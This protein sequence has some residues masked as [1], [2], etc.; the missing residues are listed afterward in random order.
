M[1]NFKPHDLKFV[2]D[3]LFVPKP[4]PVTVIP[5]PSGPLVGLIDWMDSVVPVPVESV[6]PPEPDDELFLQLVA[7]RVAMKMRRGGWFC[8]GHTHR[9]LFGCGLQ[10]ECNRHGESRMDKHALGGTH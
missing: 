10:L 9:C 8:D 5:V 7:T 6:E 2:V 4:V 3:E 1:P